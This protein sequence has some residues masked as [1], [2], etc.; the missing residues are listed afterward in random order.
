MTYYVKSAVGLQVGEAEVATN[1]AKLYSD[2]TRP[3]GVGSRDEDRTVEGNPA[4]S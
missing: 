1:S 4:G 2:M 3:L